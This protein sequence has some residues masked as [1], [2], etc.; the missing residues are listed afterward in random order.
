[1]NYHYISS[2]PNWTSTNNSYFINFLSDFSLGTKLSSG[3]KCNGFISIH[4]MLHYNLKWINLMVYFKVVG[5]ILMYKH[6]TKIILLSNTL[7]S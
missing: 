5:A 2:D 4:W 3:S 1:M 6:R 7:D